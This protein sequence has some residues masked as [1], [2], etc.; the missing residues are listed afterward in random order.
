MTMQHRLLRRGLIATLAV[1]A[2]TMTTLLFG[3]GVS[4]A[5]MDL[6]ADTTPPQV[7]SVKPLNGS[8]DAAPNTNIGIQFSEPMN[9]AATEAA[10]KV[11]MVGGARVTGT[12][13]W[14]GNSVVFDP[15]NDL[16][17]GAKYVAVINTTATDETGVPLAEARTWEFK[18]A[19]IPTT[20]P[21]LTTVTSVPR[22]AGIFTGTLRSGD[23]SGLGTDDNAFFEVDGAKTWGDSSTTSRL[24]LADWFALVPA[25]HNLKSLKVTYRGSASAKCVQIVSIFNWRTGLWE[26][27]DRRTVDPNE[28]TIE[29]SPVGS[30]GDYISGSSTAPDVLV[31]VQCERY[32]GWGFT[33]R[34]DLLNVTFEL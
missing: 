32:D 31:R 25:Q 2:L 7:L 22:A 19:G 12:Y 13:E 23:V 18:I 29:A 10:F 20:T 33:S 21:V 16:V 30:P 4:A 3:S 17:V 14:F 27:L 26:K 24:V 15:T 5:G 8:A 6:A 9:K 28:V 1:S 11:G 34:G